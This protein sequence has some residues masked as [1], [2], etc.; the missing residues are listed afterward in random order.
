MVKNILK[1]KISFDSIFYSNQRL[2]IEILKTES[3]SLQFL[4]VGFCLISKKVS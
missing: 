4:I 1:D 3:P 2:A